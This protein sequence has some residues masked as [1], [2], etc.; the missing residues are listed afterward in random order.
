[1][2]YR[3]AAIGIALS[4]TTV[5]SQASA[6]EARKLDFGL[7]ADVERSSNV[8]RTSTERAALRGITPEDTVFTTLATVDLLAPIGRQSVFL[9]GSGGYSFYDKND[10]LN[11]ERLDFTGGLNAHL[12]PC[13]SVVGGGYS[14]GVNLVD[15]P[16]LVDNVENIQEV[17]RANLDLTC[18]NSTGLGVVA[19]VSKEWTSND[20]ASLTSSDYERTR[21][22]V[23][24]SY[25][26]PALGVIT[27]FTTRET[28]DYQNRILDSGYDLSSYGITYQR[29]L[30][31]R[32]QGTATVAYTSVD[33]H[34]SFGGGSMETT[35]YAASLT[36]RASSRLSFSGS[37]DNSITP[38]SGPGR[39]YDIGTA[40]RLSAEYDLG[41][42][43]SITVGG[44]RVERESKGIILA[45]TVQ[46]TNSTTDSMFGS[47]KYK[48][49]ERLSFGLYGGRE[50]RS[51]NA[52]QFDYSNN[53]IGVS[54]DV[55]F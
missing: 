34:T 36:Y 43:I 41:S 22:N 24:V 14:R 17:K 7:H 55:A 4:V 51:T 53:R 40:Y 12:G 13:S 15:D 3:N 31:A 5:S 52:R 45:P 44:A 46:L 23:G 33:P 18:Q 28:T 26:R 19:G 27:V 9:R 48:Q 6:Q 35:T 2:L 50:K 20:L 10:K 16:I 42:R 1:M 8:A 38:S 49:S 54:A 47:V 30:G 21:Y 11:R 39:D 25:S 37:L 32:I 29:E